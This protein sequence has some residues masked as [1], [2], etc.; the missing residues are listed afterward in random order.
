MSLDVQAVGLRYDRTPILHGVSLTLAAGEIGCLLGPS[1]CG[2]T[3]LL[4]AIAGLEPIT[5]GQI[6]VAGH[7][8]SSAGHRVAP[9]RRGIGMVFQDLALLG[10]LNSLDNVMLGLHRLPRAQ[11]RQQARQWLERV[12]LGDRAQAYPHQLS[13]GQQQRVALARRWPRSRGCCCST[14]RFRHSTPPCGNRWPWRCAPCSRNSA[15][16]R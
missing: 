14:S 3:S 16:P 15:P 9:E 12:G 11:R 7:T 4:R 5:D 6:V 13:G 10:H 1:G 8:L 2:K